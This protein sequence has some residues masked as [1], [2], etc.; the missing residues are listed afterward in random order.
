M[1]EDPRNQ[2]QARSLK[3]RYHE[4]KDS[5]AI[6]SLLMQ[7]KE[8]T[9]RP[10]GGFVR[11]L[12]FDGTPQYVLANKRQLQDLNRFATNPVRFSYVCMDPT[13]GLGRFYVT[14]L[15][16]E[17]LTLVKR[18]DGKH[19]YF[20]GPA[21]V[22]LNRHTEDYR[23]FISQLKIMNPALKLIQ[24]IGTDNELALSNAVVAELPDAI[25][26]KCKI[27]KRYNVKNKLRSMRITSAAQNEILKY[28]FG[29]INNAMQRMKKTD[30]KLCNV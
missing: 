23:Y 13:F 12:K 29:E 6:Y 18:R 4:Q 11:G 21:F 30:Q 26:L 7:Q 17:N 20:V 19:L 2:Q 22:H 9:T 14:P 10:N 5:D 24:A 1:S 28:I 8:H 25:R 16:Y 27:H 15:V 3:H